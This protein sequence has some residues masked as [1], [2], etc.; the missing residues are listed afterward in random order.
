MLDAFAEASGRKI[1]YQIVDR[2]SGDIAKCFAG[3]LLS[4]EKLN[5]KAE[6]SLTEMVRYRWRW[7]VQNPNGYK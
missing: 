1:P 6:Y 7:Q 5:W 3:P 4:A 2:R